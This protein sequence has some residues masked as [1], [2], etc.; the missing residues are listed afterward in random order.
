VRT[1]G[2]QILRA[3]ALG[4]SGEAVKVRDRSNYDTVGYNR[5]D[6]LNGYSAYLDEFCDGACVKVNPGMAR[7]CASYGNVFANNSVLNA[8]RAV[9]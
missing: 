7:Q 4:S 2:D 6:Y 3:R 8:A 9:T 1:C 5:F